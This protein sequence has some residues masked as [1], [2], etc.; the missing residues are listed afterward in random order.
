ML[1]Q[2]QE[3]EMKQTKI[4]KLPKNWKISKIGEIAE[5]KGGKRL[6]KGVKFSEIKTPYPYIRVSDFKNGI[7]EIADLEYLTKEIQNKIKRYVIS[8]EDV[9]ISIA[10]TIGLAGLIPNELDGANLTE[11]A[12]KIC[13]LKNIEKRFLS[14]ALSSEIGQNQIRSYLGKTTQPKLALFR[15]EKL[16]VPVPPY[17][18]QEKIASILGTVDDLINKYDKIIDSTK[19][20]KTGLMQ[21]LLTKGIGHEKFKQ[22]AFGKIPY[23]WELT[24]IGD[25]SEVR[26][27]GTPSRSNYEYFNGEIP[28]AK[29][30]EIQYNIITNTEEKITKKALDETSAKMYSKNTLLFAMYGQ[31]VTR[32]KCAILGINA[33]INQACAAI[34]PD[35]S[36]EIWFLFYWLQFHYKKIRTLSSGSHQSNFNLNQVRKLEVGRPK[37]VEQKKIVSILSS[38]DSKNIDLESKRTSLEKLK[39]GLMQKLLTG[40]IRV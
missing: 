20:L 9:Y 37:I 23:D 31:G 17:S 19:H 38:F 33:A 18:E 1:L 40:Q 28:W 16:L 3:K 27:G 12:A 30:T 29:T 2:E 13:N 24:T 39:K 4:G 21:K 26:T 15:I 25:C 8:S 32:G 34:S 35:P 5:V 14:L 22:I 11:N 7:V 10:G 36:L 6:P